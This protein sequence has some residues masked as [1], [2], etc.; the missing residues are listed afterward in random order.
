MDWCVCSTFSIGLRW[1][2]YASYPCMKRSFVITLYILCLIEV[3]RIFPIGS[4]F[5][6]EVKGERRSAKFKIQDN[7]NYYFSYC[8]K[9]RGYFSIRS[10][11]YLVLSLEII[12]ACLG[13]GFSPYSSECWR[14]CSNLWDWSKSRQT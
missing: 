1:L 2:I 11:D 9:S 3:W 14:R 4:V 6:W 13:N 8:V 5:S 12:S 7:L 10:R